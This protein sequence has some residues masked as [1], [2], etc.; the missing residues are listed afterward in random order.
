MNRRHFLKL[1]GA[2]PLVGLFPPAW[3]RAAGLTPRTLV[4]VEL[5]GGNDGINTL[6]PYADPGYA[7][8]RSSLRIDGD[9]LLKLSE[10]VGLHPALA[11]I[12]HKK[13]GQ[14]PYSSI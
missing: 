5:K 11:R 7:A 2:A 12:F 4:L 14:G 13:G 9:Q 10:Q 6:V 8:A 3:V 1:C